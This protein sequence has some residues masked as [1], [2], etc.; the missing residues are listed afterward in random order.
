LIGQIDR[1]V[2][3][4]SVLRQRL[5]QMK[6]ETASTQRLAVGASVTFRS[7]QSVTTPAYR[8]MLHS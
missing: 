5:G 7:R 1:Q 8:S 6:Q 2:E 4:N 3:L